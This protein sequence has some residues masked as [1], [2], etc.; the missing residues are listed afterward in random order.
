M[1]RSPATI[2]A[3]YALTAT[4]AAGFGLLTYMQVWAQQPTAPSNSQVTEVDVD[5]TLPATDFS[6]DH[7]RAAAAARLGGSAGD[8]GEFNAVALPRNP[9]APDASAIGSKTCVS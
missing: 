2:A 4:V 1:K 7:P 9:L 6:L 8:K 3:R 5:S